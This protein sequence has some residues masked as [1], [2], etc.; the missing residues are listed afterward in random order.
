MFPV[1]R[2]LLSHLL[3]KGFGELELIPGVPLASP[4]WC[5]QYSVSTWRIRRAANGAEHENEE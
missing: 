1:I 4:L 5:L 2:E 3:G